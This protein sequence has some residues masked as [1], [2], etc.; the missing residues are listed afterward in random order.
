MQH[1][2]KANNLEERVKT[3]EKVFLEYAKT[4]TEEDTKKFSLIANQ[5]DTLTKYLIE[6]KKNQ[7]ILFKCFGLITEYI[8]HQ[9]TNQELNE[10]IK[11]FA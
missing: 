1:T 9:K 2:Q 11:N 8:Q 10:K 7:D 3:L 6:L 5:F 4:T